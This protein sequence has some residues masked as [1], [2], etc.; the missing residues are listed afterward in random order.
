MGAV[1]L[2][3]WLAYH[4]SPTRLL[5][6]ARYWLGTPGGSLQVCR[7]QLSA[8]AVTGSVH[9]ALSALSLTGAFSTL[10]AHPLVLSVSAIGSMLQCQKSGSLQGALGDCA[11]QASGR[12]HSCTDGAHS[13]GGS[14]LLR[15]LFAQ[16]SSVVGAIGS[17]VLL[18]H[19]RA[20][21]VCRAGLR[22]V[23]APTVQHPILGCRS[24]GYLLAHS[25]V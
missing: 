13:S 16:V 3:P 12:C 14:T 7:P 20:V 5:A 18:W 10:L 17:L 8:P 6:C 24:S 23:V 9:L 15:P 25:Q 11:G 22:H 2:S 4:H 1:T 21:L 19:S